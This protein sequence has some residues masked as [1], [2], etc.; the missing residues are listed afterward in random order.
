MVKNRGKLF[1]NEVI[2]K[3]EINGIM[4]TTSKIYTCQLSDFKKLISKIQTPQKKEVLCRNC[5]L[6]MSN[7]KN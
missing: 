3:T 1:D 5:F 2:T 7:V 6:S 4:S